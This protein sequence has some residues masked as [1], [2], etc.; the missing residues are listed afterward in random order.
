MSLSWTKEYAFEPLDQFQQVAPDLYMQRRN[1]RELPPASE[2]EPVQWE[3]ESRT[4]SKE[5]YEAYME[6]LNSPAQEQVV[7]DIQ[8]MSL[9]QENLDG[10][11]LITMA[12][13]AEMYEILSIALLQ[14]QGGNTNGTPIRDV[15]HESNENA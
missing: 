3:Y 7:K 14:L 15:S 1:G 4:I 5:Q 12:A 9:N 8:S 6:Q 2:G 10:K 11:T 13:I